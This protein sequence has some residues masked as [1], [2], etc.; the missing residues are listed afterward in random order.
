VTDATSTAALIA[1]IAPTHVVHL[2]AIAAPV[3]AGTNPD[4][5]WAVNL[6]GTLNVARA[7]LAHAPKATLV[8]AGSGLVY[9]DTARAGLPLTEGSLLAP[10]T[11][12]AA[13]KAAADLALG[14]LVGQGL[15]VIRCR[16]FNHSG[17][18][19]T[20]D[21][22]L[23]S[24]A[25]QIARIERGLQPP[26]LQ[27]GNLEAERDFLD[28]RD[29]ADAYA[30]CVVRSDAIAPGTLFNIASGVPVSIRSLLDAMVAQAAV[31]ITV[32]V[33]PARW[34]ANDLPRIIGNAN[35]ARTAL[36][37]VPQHSTSGLI[38]DLL[39]HARAVAS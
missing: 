22:V 4:L 11:D 13:T 25:A 15:R 10:N 8:F 1:A 24:F 32:A 20:E 14:A 21:F 35:A 36:D 2:A 37:W 18:G 3:K 33:D 38:K 12:Y 27:V 17:P 30:R 39:A 26:V 19:Q 5:A 9:G 34:R 29:V 31:P 16:P 7:L 28:V 6:G 23:P